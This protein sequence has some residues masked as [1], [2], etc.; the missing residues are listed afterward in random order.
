MMKTNAILTLEALN[1]PYQLQEYDVNSGVP[2]TA[3]TLGQTRIPLKQSF[4]TLVLRGDCLGVLLAV[5]PL[6]TQL[7]FKALAQC[8]LNQNTRLVPR[9]EV[10]SLTGYEPGEVTALACRCSY[11]VFVD[12]RAEDLEQIWVSAGKPNLIVGLAP[13]DYL[14]LVQGSFAAIAK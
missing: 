2:V 9:S 11:P 5:L 4:K 8:S 1:I 3:S 7:S 14:Q 12:R 10:E 6:H 13:I